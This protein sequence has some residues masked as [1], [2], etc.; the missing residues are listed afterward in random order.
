MTTSASDLTTRGP[1]LD[2]VLR[3]LDAF[4]GARSSSVPATR[5]D[6]VRRRARA[7]HEAMR[8]GPQAVFYKTCELV[9]VPYPVRYAFANVYTQR[10]VP[11]PVMHIVNRL[12]VV[13]FRTEAGVKT[14]LFSPSDVLANAETRYFKRLGAGELARLSGEVG[15][16]TPGGIVKTLVQKL[17]APQ[18]PTVLDHLAAL[19][20]RPE[21]VDYVSFDHLHT[22]DVR[23]WM[24]GDG[25]TPVFPNAKLLV[26]KTEWESARGL[27]PSQADWYCPNG[28]RGIDPARVL[29]FDDDLSLGE[30]VALVRT[31]GHTM[32]NHSL[33]AHTSEGVLVSS[34]NGV[35]LDNYAPHASS[36]GPVRAYAKNTG[37]EV[38]LNGNTQES[39]V[40][41]YIS[42][43]MEKEIAGPSRKDPAF[44]NV[45]CSSEASPWWLFPGIAPT[46]RFG[47][48]ELGAFVRPS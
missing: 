34:E 7:F 28:T 35:S 22:Q 23:N 21:A 45:V 9:R 15:T 11:T 43:V 25:R 41:Q 16:F 27:I 40:E 13:Q 18:A 10:P 26:T 17:V 39:S 14:L 44:P 42:M 12:Y 36:I 20:L 32:G 4:R 2:G 1:E 8:A 46:L 31:P 37:V 5:L 24:G 38:V 47:D 29:P 48:L 33:V 19:G 6:E 3:T 30:G